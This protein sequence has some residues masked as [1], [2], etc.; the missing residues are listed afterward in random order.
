MLTITFTQLRNNA[1][2]FFDAVERGETIEVY[3]HGKPVAVLSPAREAIGA[4]WKGANPLRIPG[5]SLSKVVLSERR[6]GGR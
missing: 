1:K 5:V 6:E 4:R 2:K 3:R